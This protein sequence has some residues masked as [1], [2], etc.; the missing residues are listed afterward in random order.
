M[1]A[2]PIE[3]PR[4]SAPLTVSYTLS[5]RDYSRFMWRAL[6]RVT[7]SLLGLA[8]IS[9]FLVAGVNALRVPGTPY[10]YAGWACPA[11]FVLFAGFMYWASARQYDQQPSF[12][13]PRSV[14]FL[15]DGILCVDANTR[16]H[17]VYSALVKVRVTDDQLLLFT[18]P[19]TAYIIP[20][21]AI[22]AESYKP[23]LDLLRSNV[24][25]CQ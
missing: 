10:L 5:R 4:L 13:L 12:R 6:A 16:A 23:I 11:V 1:E 15:D 9:G 22:P 14:T 2:T 17:T 20:R 8:A 7:W 25:D 18:R 3:N 19:N 21:A 24:R